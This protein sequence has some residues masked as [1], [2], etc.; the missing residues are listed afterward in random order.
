MK[1]MVYHKYGPPEV[2]TLAEVPKPSPK[3]NEVLIKIHA[4]SVSAG[5]WRAR[6]LDMPAG[7]GLIGRLVFGLFRPR[8]PILGSEISGEIE[9]IGKDVTK[10]N[11]GDK[12]VAYANFGGHAEYTTMPEEGAIVPKP[13][14]LNF[15][16]AA[17]IPF[18]GTTALIFLRDLGQIRPG[19]K[20][21]V[22]GASGATGSAAVQLAKHFGAEVTGVTSTANLKLVESI[23][24]DRVIDYT[25]EDFTKNGETYDIIV[26]TV[27]TAPWSVSKPSLN[28]TGRLLV[29]SGSLK[30][31]LQSGCVSKKDGKK[32]V[33]GVASGNPKDLQLLVDLA[34]SGVFKPIIDRSYPLEDA[35]EAHAYVDSGR[36]KGS[37]ILTVRHNATHLLAAA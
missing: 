7:F 16:E 23:G 18:G 28:K 32:L 10:F 33:S 4:T 24:A 31:M 11:V 29:I 13:A 6:S 1:A 8:Q 17:A 35:A 25:R 37:V 15:E 12:V 19:E 34:E 5:D 26:D 14:T 22:V 21:L 30:D 36:K 20:V 27:G 9:A 3:D 2:V